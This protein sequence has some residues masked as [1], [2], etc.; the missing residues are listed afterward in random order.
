MITESVQYSLP[1]VFIELLR[2]KKETAPTLTFER[3]ENDNGCR[4]R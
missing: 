4:Y 2:D 1:F 3:M